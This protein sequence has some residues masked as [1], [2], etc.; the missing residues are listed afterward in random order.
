MEKTFVE[1]V[2]LLPVDAALPL[3]SGPVNRLIALAA[4]NPRLLSLQFLAARASMIAGRVED[5]S[6]IANRAA[7]NNPDKA[8][9]AQFAV[10]TL[11]SAGR[12]P[13]VLEMAKRWRETT[14]SD[15]L[16]SDQ[17]IAVAYTALENFTAA[18]DQLTPHLTRASAEPEKFRALIAQY[19]HLQARVVSP[20]AAAEL[21]RP[22]L[23]QSAEWR[24]IWMRLAGANLPATPAVAWLREVEPLSLKGEFTERL[25]LADCWHA[26]AQ[27]SQDPEHAAHAS[28]VLAGVAEDPQIGRLSADELLVIASLQESQGSQAGA[29]ATYRRA[30]AL[31]PQLPVAQNNLAMILARKHESLDEALM[32]AQQ[33]VNSAPPAHR[34][35]IHDTLAFVRG[36]RGEYAAAVASL[37]QALT[38]KPNEP[39]YQVRL[40]NMLIGNQQI[41]RAKIILEELKSRAATSIELQ[42]EIQSLQERVERSS[43]ARA[44]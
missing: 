16:P 33:A 11:A 13:E 34:A 38:L 41:N 22:R 28:T 6:Q 4:E 10:T 40:A 8:A 27:R 21:L 14:P 24:V 25:T 35:G 15:T 42:K 39:K 1:V 31:N 5:A 17:M 43:P 30:L 29:E 20:D 37:E 9:P 18:R 12:W 44:S 2:K 19:A 36:Q 3:G 26:V 32:L 23:T 7:Q